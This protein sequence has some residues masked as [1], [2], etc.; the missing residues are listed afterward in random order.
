MHFI[1]LRALLALDDFKLNLIALLQGL[2]AFGCNGAVMDKN[3]WPIVASNETE[4]FSVV[5]PFHLTFD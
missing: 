2:I 3:I 5:K 1:G 4:P